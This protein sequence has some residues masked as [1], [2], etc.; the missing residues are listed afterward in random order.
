MAELIASLDWN[1]TSLG[2]MAAW[3]EHLTT[4]VGLMLH[5]R[6]PMAILWG[7]QGVLLYNDA[8]AK[9]AG[10]RHP[11]ILG[12]PVREAW[13]EAADF[14]ADVL[15]R[16][17]AGD[18]LSYEDL[19]FD[20]EHHG[21]ATAFWMTLH[22]SALPGADGRPAGVL[23]LV[24]DTTDTVR[25][26][27]RL[28]TERERFARLFDQ[29]PS[30]MAMLEGPEH[31]I[32]LANPNLLKL[33]GHRPVLGRTV[34]D[35]LPDARDQ[36]YVDLLDQVHATGM[37]FAANG[38]RYAEQAMPDGP[39]SERYVDFVFQPIRDAAGAVSGIFVE[40]FDVTERMAA[41]RLRVALADFAGALN[42]LDSLADISH[43]AATLL[44]ER[45]DVSR[46][47]LGTVD[48]ATGAFTV[49]R[50]WIPPGVASIAGERWMHDH[51]RFCDAMKRGDVVRVDDARSDPRTSGADRAESIARS[52]LA[53]VNVPILAHG[54]LVAILFVHSTQPRAWST[55]EIDFVREI[56]NRTWIAVERARGQAAL[57]ESERRLR[58]ANGSLETRI[59]QR[60]AELMEVEARLR[61]SQKMEAIGQLTGGIAHDFNN[62]LGSMSAS[63]QVL[64]KRVAAGKLDGLGR[65]TGMAQDALRRAAQLTQR[66]LAFS[67]RQTLDPRPVDVGR[68]IGGLED[69]IRRTVGPSVTLEV[70]NAA[71][72]WPIRVD[73]VQLESALLNMAINARDAMAPDGGRLTFTTTNEWLDERD[74]VRIDMVPGPCVLIQVSDTGTGMTPEVVERVFE[75]FFTTKPMGQGTGLGLSMVYGF[76][77][78]SG[79][80]IRVDTRPGQGTTMCLYFPRFTGEAEVPIAPAHDAAMEAGR[81]Q[82]RTVLLV[83][84]EATIRHI[85]VEQ[86]EEAGYEVLAAGDGPSGLRVL[87]KPTRIDLLLTDV[88][89]PGG[90]NGRQVADAA[91]VQRP[92]LKV[93]FITGYVESAAVGNG[94]LGPGMEVITKPFDVAALVEKVSAMLEVQS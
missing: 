40:G 87:E 91:R 47:G 1:R 56:G 86:L 63:L 3:P 34:A 71:L 33:V 49:E 59:A 8:Y 25:A 28:G 9:V 79:G 37:P 41:E 85:V 58:E 83:E 38:S 16:V 51:G 65:Y 73:A 7:P 61:Q 69:L 44:G 35:A 55:L 31:R 93:L 78:Q 75:P 48:A 50:D 54:R 22:Y 32:E 82:G 24:Q 57:I 23:A 5:A 12:L 89:L 43:A 11:A 46:A 15:R 26:K 60:T 20:L 88:G 6:C 42:S 17:L 4:P 14:N 27:H 66:L 19:A 52:A 80:Q 30:F 45:L 77:R 92:G 70:I 68:L 2:P 72:P 84:D 81:G 29:S 39:V 74:A 64:D 67:R 53:F 21:V 62:L 13:P 90:L 18:A 76:V 94:L 36:G 10:S